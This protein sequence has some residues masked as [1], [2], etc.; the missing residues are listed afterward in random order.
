MPDPGTPRIETWVPF[1]VS[2]IKSPDENTVLVGHSM[3]CQAILRFLEKIP[4]GRQ[5]GKVILVGGFTESVSNLETDEERGIVK[6]WLETPID[7]VKVKR[8]AKEIAAFF[9]DNDRWV[10]LENEKAIKEKLDAKTI[11]EHG[12]HHW[13]DR[14]SITEVPSILNEI[15]S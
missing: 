15:V 1:L 8:S 5:A 4:E 7:F 12:M 13:G 2:K 14:D 6:P 9:S 3:G 10:P 11:I